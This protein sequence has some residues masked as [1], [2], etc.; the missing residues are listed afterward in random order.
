MAPEQ[1]SKSLDRELEL[2]RKEAV[3]GLL[4]LLYPIP[5][6]EAEMRRVLIRQQT[7]VPHLFGKRWV[8]FFI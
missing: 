4:L 3:L 7:P 2:V 8:S 6:S 1:V 5:L